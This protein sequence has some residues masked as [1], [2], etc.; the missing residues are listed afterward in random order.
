MQK[1]QKSKTA[2]PSLCVSWRNG[3][4]NV[5]KLPRNTYAQILY[6]LCEQRP[7]EAELKMRTVKFIFRCMNSGVDFVRSVAR[8]ILSVPNE[9]S[10]MYNNFVDCCNFFRMSLLIPRD[11]LDLDYHNIVRVCGMWTR[12][13]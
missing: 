9:K 11:E 4:K 5:W 10:V 7:I 1:Q 13:V 2:L 12:R 3:L 6:S 8:H